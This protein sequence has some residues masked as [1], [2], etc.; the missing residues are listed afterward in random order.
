MAIY[1]P[2]LKSYAP[3]YIQRDDDASATDIRLTYGITVLQQDFPL[4]LKVKQPYKNDWRDRHGDDEY[5]DNL[6]YEAI[7]Y[8][9]KCVMFTDEANSDVARATM[10]EQLYEFRDFIGRGAFR[11]YS[12]WTKMGFQNCRLEEF[13]EPSEDD[14]TEMDG[15]CR[16][17][18]NVKIKINDPATVMTLSAGAIVEDE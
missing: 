16:L 9:M 11:I 2:P 15:H 17:I 13:P 3:L 8:S 5:M 18:F 6:Y 4:Q 7:S 10:K 14:F 1:N 12:D